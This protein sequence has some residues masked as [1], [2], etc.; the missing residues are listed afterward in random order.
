MIRDHPST[1]EPSTRTAGPALFRSFNHRWAPALG[2]R[3]GR[4]AAWVVGSFES[5]KMNV[6]FRRSAPR[7]VLEVR[8]GASSSPLRHGVNRQQFILNRIQLE[9][10]MTRALR[11]V[12]AR[13][14]CSLVVRDALRG[15]VRG[16]VFLIVSVSLT[17]GV[18][19]LCTK[20]A[21]TASKYGRLRRS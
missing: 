15:A 1:P 21:A 6:A 9:V 11:I 20:A 7:P 16:V 13:R 2:G 18:V 17:N 5:V 4:Q 14:D 19:D 8:I 12:A 3:L 10:V